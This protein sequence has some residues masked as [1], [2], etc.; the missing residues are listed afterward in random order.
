M[1]GRGYSGETGEDIW[2]ELRGREIRRLMG[3][4]L[5][6]RGRGDKRAERRGYL[7]E[8]KRGKIRGLR[9]KGYGMEEIVSL[10]CTPLFQNDRT[11]SPW[12]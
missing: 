9:G 11:S 6:L 12:A 1:R 4:Y 5:E 8:F 3:G 2:E 10:S 7:E